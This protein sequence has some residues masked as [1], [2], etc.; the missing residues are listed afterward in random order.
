VAYTYD[1][2]TTTL[3]KAHDEGATLAP[4]FS[5]EKLCLSTSYA[6]PLH[7]DEKATTTGR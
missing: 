3:P 7:R 5:P 6:T 2:S 4:H 1:R